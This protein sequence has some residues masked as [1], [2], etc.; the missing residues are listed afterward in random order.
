MILPLPPPLA[1]PLA[2]VTIPNCYGIFGPDR[3][4]RFLAVESSRKTPRA[5]RIS[6]TGE[7]LGEIAE[8]AGGAPIGVTPEREYVF[9]K[10]GFLATSPIEED[11]ESEGRIFRPV[12]FE[13]GLRL[14]YGLEDGF[15]A[16][17]PFGHRIFEVPTV[18][19]MAYALAETPP[20]AAFLGAD[21]PDRLYVR[22]LRLNRQRI[23]RLESWPATREQW[24]AFVLEGDRRAYFLSERPGGLPAP[25]PLPLMRDR[26]AGKGEPYFVRY[27]VE[28]DLRNGACRPLARVET[29]VAYL[30]RYLLSGVPPVWGVRDVVVMR[31]AIAVRVR[32]R[33]FLLPRTGKR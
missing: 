25:R 3:P 31:S 1:E 23:V 17:G 12:L 4:D 15:R 24:Q 33:I 7:R 29:P 11:S 6:A 30:G 18:R 14:E 28:A 2:S 13:G 10:E 19:E 27:L 9:P 8:Y 26:V 21:R 5:Y 16:L 20:T 32:D 22:D